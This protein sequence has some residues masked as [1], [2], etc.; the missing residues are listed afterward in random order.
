MNMSSPHSSTT[1]NILP[2]ATKLSTQKLSLQNMALRG[3]IMKR[4]ISDTIK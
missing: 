3:L 1:K 2:N 4:Q